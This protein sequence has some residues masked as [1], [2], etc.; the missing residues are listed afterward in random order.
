MFGQPVDKDTHNVPVTGD[1]FASLRFI[2]TVWRT[3][4]EEVDQ[5]WI[6]R[7]S[8][9]Q[10]RDRTGPMARESDDV[11][12]KRQRSIDGSRSVRHLVT[13]HRHIFNLRH[14]INSTSD[15]DSMATKSTECFFRLL[16]RAF[17]LVRPTCTSFSFSLFL[18][19]SHFATFA[20]LNLAYKSVSISI[21]QISKDPKLELKFRI[22]LWG[23]QNKAHNHHSHTHSHTYTFG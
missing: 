5:T 1:P 21:L 20:A 23:P 12:R 22:A 14:T 6:P 16:P 2:Y 18:S 4:I 10:D 17:S 9:R 8:P 11:Y 3:M 7:A 13:I 15:D 19:Y